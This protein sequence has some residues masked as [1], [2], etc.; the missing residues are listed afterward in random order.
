MPIFQQKYVCL[1]CGL[2]VLFMKMSPFKN[3]IINNSAPSIEEFSTLQ[4][5]VTTPLL[6]LMASEF[7]V[8]VTEY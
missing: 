4:S 3:N 7:E 6:L 2:I 8:Y 1:L 5:V